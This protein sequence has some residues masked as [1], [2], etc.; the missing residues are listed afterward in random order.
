MSVSL[1]Q[2]EHI[3]SLARLS[4]DDK[5]KQQLSEELSSIIGYIEQLK[6]VNT[7]NVEPLSH[8]SEITNVLREDV[9]ESSFSQETALKNAPA[10]EKG[11]FKV[12]K[13]IK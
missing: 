12:P 5:E 4:F 9:V 7:D 6:T 3:A 11:F 13:V 10:K 1:K 2:V 8:P